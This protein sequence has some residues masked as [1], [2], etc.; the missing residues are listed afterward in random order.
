MKI[1]FVSLLKV[2]NAVHDELSIY[3]GKK[4]KGKD[5]NIYTKYE[6]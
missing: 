3:P 6:H 4:E 1:L 5:E 2:E